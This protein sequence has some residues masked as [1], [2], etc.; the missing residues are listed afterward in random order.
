MIGPAIY[1]VTTH[2]EILAFDE[3]AGEMTYSEYDVFEWC[4]NCIHDGKASISG[5][6]E[7][8]NV[9][10]LYNT[11][12]IAGLSTGITYGEIFCK[13]RICQRNDG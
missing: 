6:T 2:R 4:E 3:D 7:L 8:T 11:Q 12:K 1:T 10:I 13:S 9:N 5:D